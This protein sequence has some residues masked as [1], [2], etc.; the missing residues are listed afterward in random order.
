MGYPK[1]VLG[2]AHRTRARIYGRLKWQLGHLDVVDRLQHHLPAHA[3]TGKAVHK[4]LLR[5]CWDARPPG[6]AG[7]GWLERALLVLSLQPR[8]SHNLLDI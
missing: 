5:L 1:N 4:L 6:C 7:T 2:E 3:I 8:L